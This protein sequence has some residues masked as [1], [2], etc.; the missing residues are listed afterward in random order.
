[1]AAEVD[2]Y[3]MALANIGIGRT[4]AD[5]N[6]KTEE[7]RQCRK[8][9]D[10]CRDECLRNFPWSWARTAQALELVDQTFPGWGYVYQHPTDCLFAL[11]I[12]PQDGLRM[13]VD[14]FDLW[15]ERM[16]N[17]PLRV[18]FELALRT[19]GKSRVIVTDLPFAWLLS[20]TRVTTTTVFDVDF[21]NMFGWRLGYAIAPALKADAKMA[22][23]AMDM[24]EAM[25]GRA[26]ANDFNESYSDPEPDAPS[27]AAR[28]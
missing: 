10:H 6:E 26:T 13:R 27:I 25:R 8:W 5:P 4:I 2:I 18:P 28:C 15:Q 20:I 9:F 1:M 17:R 7:A 23:N 12:M 11:A 22:R 16:T 14:W 21:V 19:D 3:N 24:Y